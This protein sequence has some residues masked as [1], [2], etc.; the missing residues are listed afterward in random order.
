MSSHRPEMASLV[1]STK[2]QV[3]DNHLDKYTG[4]FYDAINYVDVTDLL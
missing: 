2:V 1:D 3:T 4:L